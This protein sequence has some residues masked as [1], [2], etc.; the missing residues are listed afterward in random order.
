MIEHRK[1]SLFDA[2]DGAILAHACNAKGIW[3]S[4][5]AK[6]FKE[7]FPGNYDSYAWHCQ[8][9]SRPESLVGT[10]LLLGAEAPNFEG[11]GIACM[12]TSKGYGR[13]VDPP[14][15]ILLST[16]CA[17]TDLLSQAPL[18]CEIHMPKIN[19]G[20]FNV[21]WEETQYE[22]ESVLEDWPHNK[23]VVWTP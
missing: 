22:L 1:G 3:G 18:G 10:T 5:I 21:P 15:E 11:W 2:P 12:F 8:R 4:G 7:R 9:N 20:L 14:E 16:Q 17:F 6:Q 13:D 23:V 19:S